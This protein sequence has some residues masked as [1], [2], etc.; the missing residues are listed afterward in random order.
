MY[1]C[2]S[3]DLQLE[4]KS[5]KADDRFQAQQGSL[6]ETKKEVVHL[7]ARKSLTEGEALKGD[8]PCSKDDD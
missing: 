1:V 5:V 7:A 2:T 4:E 3:C 8:K 6:E